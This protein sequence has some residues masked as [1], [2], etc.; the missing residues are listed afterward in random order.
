MPE[1]SPPRAVDVPFSVPRDSEWA[2][3]SLMQIKEHPPQIR[4][5]Q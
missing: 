5:L 4:M 2:S 1:P 3:N